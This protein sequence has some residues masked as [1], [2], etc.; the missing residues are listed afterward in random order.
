MPRS[1]SCRAPSTSFA[2]RLWNTTSIPSA[3]ARRARACP[4]RPIPTIPSV[5]PPRCIPI[6]APP[7]PQPVHSPARTIRSPSPA[8]RAVIS[9]SIRATSAVASVVASGVLLTITPAAFAAPRSMWSCPTPKLATSRQRCGPPSK[10]GA[11]QPSPMVERMASYALSA[12]HASAGLSASSR[13][14]TSKRLSHSA[15]VRPGNRL[16]TNTFN[17][18]SPPPARPRPARSGPSRRPRRAPPAPAPRS[19][20]ARSGAGGG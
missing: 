3:R 18:A 10:A 15:T 4:I 1:G 14:V 11:D 5:R 9:I 13:S 20:P 19:A 2:E 12:A 16:V 6:R 8:R 17:A 7:G